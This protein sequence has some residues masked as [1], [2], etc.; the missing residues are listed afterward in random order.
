MYFLMKIKMGKFWVSQTLL[1]IEQNGGKRQ[2]NYVHGGCL[3]SQAWA[4]IFYC[5]DFNKVCVMLSHSE[6]D[7]MAWDVSTRN[8]IFEHLRPLPCWSWHFYI[9]PQ[10]QL[11]KEH[12]FSWKLKQRNGN[13]C[14]MLLLSARCYI[15]AGIHLNCGLIVMAT[16]A[17]FLPPKPCSAIHFLLC[18]QMTLIRE[19]SCFVYANVPVMQL[20]FLISFILS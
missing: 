9:S 13:C 20:A 10:M 1:M 16:S 11:T 8:K 12:C 15:S 5:S 4:Q 3:L 14:D 19:W 17:W 6:N 7:W 2:L 18:V